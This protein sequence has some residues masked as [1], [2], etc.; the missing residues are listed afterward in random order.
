[1][2]MASTLHV[3]MSFLFEYGERERDMILSV[4]KGSLG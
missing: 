4:G 1:M 3:H 2:M